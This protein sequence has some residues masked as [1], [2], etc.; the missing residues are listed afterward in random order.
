VYRVDLPTVALHALR[1]A[2]ARW[3]RGLPLGGFSPPLGDDD[4]RELVDDL[5][6]NL[7]NHLPCHSDREG[8]YLPI[9]LAAPLIHRS[10]P[11]AAVGSVEGLRQELEDL[12]A[13]LTAATGHPPAAW[14]GVAAGERLG[15]DCLAWRTLVAACDV[16]IAS[17]SPMGRLYRAADLPV[18][19]TRDVEFR[20]VLP[21][22]LPGM[23]FERLAF[24]P[25]TRVTGVPHTPGSR[26]Y[27]VCERGRVVLTT[28]NSR[29]ELEAGDVVVYRGDQSHGYN[30][31]Y[32]EPAVA[33]T[34]IR[35]G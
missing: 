15:L 33:Y 19:V 11:G 27:L 35:P 34:L 16:S 21:D 1:V 12:E 32:D 18:R 14:G 13:P 9:D 7:D 8:W 4:D 17:G 30:N 22:P 26:E 25:H 2:Y 5:R 6:S 23:T 31:P 24:P 28:E 20:A 29:W 3:T 10:L